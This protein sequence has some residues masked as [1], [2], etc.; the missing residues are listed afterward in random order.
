MICSLFGWRDVR[1][2]KEPVFTKIGS[3]WLFSEEFAS[4]C[5]PCWQ[6][7]M[8]LRRS[9]KSRRSVGSPKRDM[10]APVTI[11]RGCG[12]IA[13]CHQISIQH[14]RDEQ[15]WLWAAVPFFIR[16]FNSRI[17][18]YESRSEKTVNGEG[19]VEGST[20]NAVLGGRVAVVSTSSSPMRLRRPLPT[21]DRSLTTHS[22]QCP[23]P[24]DTCYLTSMVT[25]NTPCPNIHDSFQ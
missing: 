17:M 3:S 19:W 9:L 24:N 22:G 21:H 12:M 14:A 13:Q 10:R 16:I 1:R 23:T 20:A 6:S 18:Q 4:Y 11:A 25:G 7:I 5:H 8:P 15:Q 2:P